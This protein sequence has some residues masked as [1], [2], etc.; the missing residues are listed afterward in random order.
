MAAVSGA[1]SVGNGSGSQGPTY[2]SRRTLAERS[3]S[4]QRRVTTAERYALGERTSVRGARC[5]RKNASW[6]TSSASMTLPSIRYAMEKRSGRCW[7]KISDG[8]TVLRS[9]FTLYAFRQPL[10]LETNRPGSL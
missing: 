2:S 1:G 4:M 3:W 5:Q 8:S 7:S 6:T 9:P 10:Q